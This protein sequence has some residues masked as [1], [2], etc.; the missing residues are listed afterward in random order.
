MKLKSPLLINLIIMAVGMML[1]I[2]HNQNVLST[3]ITIIGIAFIVPSIINLVMLF[4]GRKSEAPGE[5]GRSNRLISYGVVASLGGIGLG[6]WMVISPETLIGIIV[7]VF[8]AMMIIAGLYNIIMLAFGHRPLRFPLWM[9]I[10]PGL[11]TIAGII[12][13]C[14]DV[15]SI[16]STVVLITGIA[17][18]AF[19]LN[20]F[21]EIGK[22]YGAHTRQ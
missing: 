11:M 13:L 8:A 9:Y 20:R 15:K 7:Y 2:F 19:A 21:V 4:Y 3:I 1:I 17:I 6:A 12:I 14:T 16:E 22:I 10:L 5:P 18:T